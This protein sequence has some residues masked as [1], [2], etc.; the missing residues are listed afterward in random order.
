MYDAFT[1]TLLFSCTS[2]LVPT[3]LLVQSPYCYSSPACTDYI[4]QPAQCTSL[5]YKMYIPP[6]CTVYIPHPAQSPS[7]STSPCL[8]L[9][10]CYRTFAL[11]L[12][13]YNIAF[14]GTGV[15]FVTAL[16]LG[17]VRDPVHPLPLCFLV[18]YPFFAY[19]GIKLLF[20]FLSFRGRRE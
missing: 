19:I 6:S 9:S 14:I 1:C 15:A 3:W 18:C 7:N 4:L 11:Y 13:S 20:L 10:L 8:L 2:L 12:W 5:A 16:V 17:R